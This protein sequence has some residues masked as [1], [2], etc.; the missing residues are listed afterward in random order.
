[1]SLN[2][3]LEKGNIIYI[4]ISV[5]IIN[6]NLKVSV[7]SLIFAILSKLRFLHIPSQ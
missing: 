3:F 1:M 2:V 7:K 5:T 6:I 4:Y